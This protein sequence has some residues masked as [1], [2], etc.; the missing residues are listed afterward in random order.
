MADENND[1]NQPEYTCRTVP[2]VLSLT[3]YEQFELVTST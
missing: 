2:F 1:N 3:M